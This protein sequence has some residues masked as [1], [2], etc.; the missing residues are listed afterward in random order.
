MSHFAEYL[1]VVMSRKF[2]AFLGGS[3]C[4]VSIAAFLLAY[5]EIFHILTSLSAPKLQVA[6]SPVSQNIS[7]YTSTSC[8]YIDSFS[9][10]WLSDCIT[11]TMY[12]NIRYLSPKLPTP[13]SMIILVSLSI[14]SLPQEQTC[15]LHDH[16]TEPILI[17]H[18]QQLRNTKKVELW[19]S[20]GMLTTDRGVSTYSSA[21]I[22]I[23]HYKSLQ[24]SCE[25][26]C[27]DW[28]TSTPS[29]IVKC[30]VWI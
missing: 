20:V 4:L 21:W 14:K 10:L 5:D 7:Y 9:K 2:T 3:Q 17:S 15:S 18:S 13:Q 19:T 12:T 1:S 27:E 29:V 25:Y 26:W 6:G 28:S 24:R 30:V 23:P 22:W 8:S 11:L 16:L